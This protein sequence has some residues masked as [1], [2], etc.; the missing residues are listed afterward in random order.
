[1]VIME[2]PHSTYNAQ[3]KL[4]HPSFRGLYL[5]I[6]MNI[7]SGGSAKNQPFEKIDFLWTTSY[8]VF[9]KA[10]VKISY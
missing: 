9:L 3:L 10:H 7:L 8:V 4:K 5:I 1:M 2:D 6:N